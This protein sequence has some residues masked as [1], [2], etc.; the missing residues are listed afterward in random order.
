MST[1]IY[2][3]A[4]RPGVFVKQAR[5]HSAERNCGRGFCEWQTST[6]ADSKQSRTVFAKFAQIANN[7]RLCAWRNVTDADLNKVT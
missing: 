2:S 7:H 1:V 4:R 3:M 5:K 6:L